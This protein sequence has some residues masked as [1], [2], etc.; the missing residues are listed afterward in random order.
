MHKINYFYLL[1]PQRA[2]SLQRIA[3]EEILDALLLVKV[4]TL[5]EGVDEQ[6]WQPKT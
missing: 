1:Q 3:Q 2:Y 4:N 6:I 5:N